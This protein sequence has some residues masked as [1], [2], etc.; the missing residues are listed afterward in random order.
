MASKTTKT[1][2]TGK[3]AKT[4][5]T[6]KTVKTVRA[7]DTLWARVFAMKTF[8]SV[9]GR[10]LQA[11]ARPKL[12]SLPASLDVALAERIFKFY[13]A[14]A[15]YDLWPISAKLADELVPAFLS[16]IAGDQGLSARLLREAHR[17]GGVAGFHEM[18]ALIAFAASGTN[19]PALLKRAPKS[20]AAFDTKHTRAAAGAVLEALDGEAANDAILLHGAA[21]WLLLQSKPDA[22]LV[23]TIR[24]NTASWDAA[25][26]G[27][28]AGSNVSFLERVAK[29]AGYGLT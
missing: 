16:A 19:T 5:K 3:T 10:A 29:A 9:E 25:G 14:D 22:K 2:K 1:A 11:E 28:E 21:L 17:R 7:V 15:P 27:Y 24:K 23:D 8:N 18:G 6:T 26:I 4:A 13:L 12:R 20:K